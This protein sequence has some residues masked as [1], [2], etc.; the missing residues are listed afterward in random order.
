L[1]L[2]EREITCVHR[3]QTKWSPTV[4]L[5]AATLF[6]VPFAYHKISG[7]I[8]NKYKE[9]VTIER[10]QATFVS[11]DGRVQIKN[12]NS[13]RW[14]EADYRSMIEKG[15]TVR[16]GSLLRLPDAEINIVPLMNKD[17]L[18]MTDPDR[19]LL[20]GM[21]RAILKENAPIVI[22]HGTDTMVQSGLYLERALLDVHV[23]IVLTG[24]MTPLGFEGSDGLQNLTE[25]LLAVRLIKPGIHVVV[26][27]Q[28]FPIGRVRKDH[29][30]ARF[31]WS[32]RP[33]A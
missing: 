31:V 23:P 8:D 24:A 17:S 11:L 10:A 5:A 22:T 25:S 7:A 27:G 33:G 26:H 2:A 18:E 14:V 6:F 21:V 13:P 29:T 30:L 4:I 9:P 32:D 16:T 12:V 20:L 3:R 19:M 28:V 1:A 15:D